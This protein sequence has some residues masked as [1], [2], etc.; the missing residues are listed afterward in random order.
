MAT[1]LLTILP[2]IAATAGESRSPSAA[3]VATTQPAATLRDAHDLYVEGY[4]DR[5]VDGDGR[6]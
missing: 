3:E 1:G 2:G 4:Y 5:A 6:R